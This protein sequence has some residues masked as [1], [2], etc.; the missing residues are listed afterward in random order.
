[1]GYDEASFP[2][3]LISGKL[4]PEER[5]REAGMLASGVIRI[6]I[7]FILNYLLKRGTI[8]G[9]TKMIVITSHIN[10]Y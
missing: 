6:Y 4:D 9:A 10:G 3:F 7:A 5:K 2:Y 8:Y 1:M